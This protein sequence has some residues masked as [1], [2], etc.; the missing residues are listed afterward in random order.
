MLI[1]N[2]SGIRGN[3][4]SKLL[5]EC[6]LVLFLVL[7][8]TLRQYSLSDCFQSSL[9]S[10]AVT[11]CAEMQSSMN[12]NRSDFCC[13][14]FASIFR[15]AFF[16]F[17]NIRLFAV[18]LKDVQWYKQYWVSTAV[19]CIWLVY[20]ILT[21]LVVRESQ[22]M[23]QAW[24]FYYCQVLHP[25][26]MHRAALDHDLWWAQCTCHRQHFLHH[27]LLLPSTR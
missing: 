25:S 15:I 1:W 3:K 21:G 9:A 7:T 24:I 8:S 10:S 11:I 13:M 19:I 20:I 4:L 6:D 16:S 18:S 26:M 17:S 2:V 22:L 27:S 23:A 14:K 12:R 5:M